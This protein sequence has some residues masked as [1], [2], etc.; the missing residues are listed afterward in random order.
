[1]R[2][3]SLF[4]SRLGTLWMYESPGIFWVLWKAVSPFIDP[5]TKKKVVFVSGRSAVKHMTSE[6]DIEVGSQ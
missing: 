3:K 4:M 1:M 6:I 2:N 5:V